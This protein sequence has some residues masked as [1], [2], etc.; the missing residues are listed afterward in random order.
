MVRFQFLPAETRFYDWFEKA[1][2]NLL[3]AG[4]Q[5]QDLFDRY[6]DVESRV[7]RLTELE[8][9]GDFIVHEVMELLTQT[10]IIPLDS[11]DIGR[12]ISSLDDTL[13]AIEAA[14]V[15]L[16]I[17]RVEQPTE[18]ARQLARLIRNGAEQVKLAM[19]HLRD[20]KSFRLVGEHI[21]KIHTIENDGD[22]VLREGL[23]ELVEHREDVFNL[24]RWKE[25][26][27]MLEQATDRLED[28]ADVLQRVIIKNG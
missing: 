16:V 8:H 4:Q 11:E 15:R 22:R 1:S 5:L 24:L 27:E 17:F 28:V 21:V 14:A 26:Y 25:I 9:R 6:D 2:A 23:N 3:E 18:R 10:F 19:P 7:A 20:K 12:L 13:D